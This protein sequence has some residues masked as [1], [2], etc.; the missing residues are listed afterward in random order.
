MKPQK[1]LGMCALLWAG[2]LTAGCSTEQ[3]AKLLVQPDTSFGRTRYFLAPSG[4]DL[5]KAKTISA[6]RRYKMPGKVDIDV[7]VIKAKAETP[8]RGAVLVLHDLSDS[9]AGYL[10]LAKALSQKGFDIVLSDFRA[11]GRSTGK[12]VTYGA[13]EKEDLKRVVDGLLA[14]KLVSETVYVFGAGMGAS[15]AIQYA[16]IDSR[17]KGVMAV[18]ACRDFRSFAKRLHLLMDPIDFD[19]LLARAGQIA[20]FK[21]NDVSALDD[22]GKLRCPVLLMHGKL[23][24][25]APYTDSEALYEA[26]NNP[27]ELML[28]EVLGHL[29]MLFAADATF[30]E[31]IEKLT[32]GKIGQATTR[33]AETPAPA[34]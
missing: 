17:V 4:E 33:P 16:A 7:W 19:K 6:A 26:A 5:V 14:E 34:K 30:V 20:K 10:P 1:T 11:H 12:Y 2:A 23:D 22:I 3:Y 25:K 21:P 9:K 13:K 32:S 29:G 8:S 31:G 27:K 24:R 28:I 15:V 18:A